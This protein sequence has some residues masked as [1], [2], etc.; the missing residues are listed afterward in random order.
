MNEIN[1][2]SKDN[3][4]PEPLKSS[5]R[6]KPESSGRLNLPNA[7][8]LGSEIKLPSHREEE[9]KEESK[10][11][12]PGETLFDKNN[13]LKFDKQIEEQRAELEKSPSL[14][15]EEKE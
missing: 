12:T 15:S 9:K 6:A 10:H 3:G 1:D 2:E 5:G 11:D 8:N 7:R 4:P 13:I 14:L